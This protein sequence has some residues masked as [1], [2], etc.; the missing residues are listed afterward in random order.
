M[1]VATM[2]RSDLEAAIL[3]NDILPTGTAEESAAV[4]AMTTEALRDA[5]AAWV[6]TGDECSGA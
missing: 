6:E 3:A 5:V 1:N 4:M 2:A